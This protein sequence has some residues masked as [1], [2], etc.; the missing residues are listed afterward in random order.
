M[1]PPTE[2]RQQNQK[3]KPESANLRPQRG[4]IPSEELLGGK[5]EVF[6]RHGDELYRLRLTR[7][8]K[9]ILQK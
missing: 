5:S 2:D 8:G 6:I 7:N 1:N 3:V 4:E 9:L